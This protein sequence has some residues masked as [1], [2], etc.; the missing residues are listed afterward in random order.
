MRCIE[1]LAAK[2]FHYH[3][4]FLHTSGNGKVAFVVRKNC[5]LKFLADFIASADMKL[6]LSQTLLIEILGLRLQLNMQPEY[7]GFHMAEKAQEMVVEH[8]L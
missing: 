8:I 5:L 1:N 2:V 4:D 7:E 6:P 3:A